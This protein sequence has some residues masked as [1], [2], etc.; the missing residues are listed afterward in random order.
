MSRPPLVLVVLA[1]LPRTGKSTL[2]RRLAAELSAPL[3]DKDAVREA[4]FGP[5]HV[6]YAPAQDSFVMTLLYQAVSFVSQ[7]SVARHAVLDGRTFSRAGQADELRAIADLLGV[8]LR[9]IECTCEAGIAR[10]RIASGE[11]SH[12]AANRTPQL[13]DELEAQAVSI[14]PPNL[15]LDTGRESPQALAAR[16][17]AYVR[18]EL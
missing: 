10:D 9:L 2:A 4:L 13:Y 16:A 15:V 5:K 1:G 14:D 8:T 7:G 11:C 6:S 17:L 18:T 12:P 3:F